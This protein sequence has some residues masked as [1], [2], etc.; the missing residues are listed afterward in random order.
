[1]PDTKKKTWEEQMKETADQ[2]INKKPFEFDM[3]AEK[4]YQ[5]YKDAGRLAMED[6]IG[7]ASAM[8]G[9][10]GNSYATTA[11]NQA[12]MGYMRELEDLAPSLYQSAIDKY[13]SEAEKQPSEDS[14]DLLPFLSEDNEEDL[15]SL[16]EEKLEKNKI[17]NDDLEEFL[18]EEE[19]AGNIDMAKAAQLFNHFYDS[20]EKIKNGEIDYRAMVENY[21]KNN[22]NGTGKDTGWAM[23]DDGG[24]NWWGGI[25]KDA[26]VVTPMGTT[27]DLDTLFK[28]LIQDGMDKKDARKLIKNMQKGLHITGKKEK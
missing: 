20:N 3:N 28:Y 13:I 23:K 6:T 24:F 7:Q 17:S 4:I 12:Y 11:G 2:I 22:A 5:Q 8:T 9:G 18:V 25:D 19:M 10:Y 1:M 21:V 27:I 14:E 15:F 26:S 16:Y